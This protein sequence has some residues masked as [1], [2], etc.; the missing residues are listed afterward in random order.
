MN[1]SVD[2]VIGS[3]FGD[4]GKGLVTNKLCSNSI[5]T[6]T[7]NIRYCSGSQAGHTVIIGNK[8]HTFHH[9]G[10]GSLQGADTY[11]SRFFI[12]NPL[13]FYN[14]SIEFYNKFKYLPKI[15]VSDASIISCPY[16]ILRNQLV[17]SIRYDNN[18]GSVGVGIF[19]TIYR[20]RTPELA[21]TVDELRNNINK[22]YSFF[23][24]KKFKL[25]RENWR[26][27]YNQYIN[28]AI[29]NGIRLPTDLRTISHENMDSIILQKYIEY[30]NFFFEHTISDKYLPNYNKYIF[31]GAQGLG[32][33]Q[34]ISK[35]N[36]PYLTPANT[37][38]L[39]VETLLNEIQ[40]LKNNEKTIKRHYVTRSYFTR[41]GK[42][43]FI[44]LNSLYFPT[45]WNIIEE[46]N[47]YHEYQQ[48]F[49]IGYFN[50]KDIENRIEK[51]IK[52]VS[53]H[54]ENIL[55]INFIDQ[56]DNYLFYLKD[57]K[58]NVIDKESIHSIFKPSLFNKIE[59]GDTQRKKVV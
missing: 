50:L 2:I 18:H 32:L 10:A 17:E 51:D 56:T 3:N 58:I 46:T 21:F 12:S 34:E 33:C 16:D 47:G 39:N 8:N 59:F 29:K 13:T 20:N 43:P 31:E 25:I 48:A 11:L 23:I 6:P 22:P 54:S 9:F 7:L 41:H 35:K 1:I 45:S 28:I 40:H 15:Y 27:W 38:S 14:E 4:E 5:Y 24:T 19:E 37:G 30:C 52:S 42:G 57:N 26:D 55:H 49:K 53:I 44:E 36:F